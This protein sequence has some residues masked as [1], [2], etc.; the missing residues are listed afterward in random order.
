MN[1]VPPGTGPLSPEFT[2]I[3][4]ALMDRFI[5]EMEHARGLIGEHTQAIRQ[6]FATEGVPATSLDPISEVERWIDE[7]LPDLR[8]RSKMAHDTAKLPDWS[9]GAANGLMSYEEK[10]VLPAAE[11]RRLGAELAA[12]YKKLDSGVLSPLS[13][14]QSYQRI[15]DALASHVNDPE[16]TAAFFA[17]L[18]RQGTL[19]LPATLRHNLAPP[20]EAT[21]APPRSDDGVLRT[22]SQAFGTAVSAGSHVP[23]F[24]QIKDSLANTALSGP[25]Q[26][27]AGLL[28]SAGSFPAK[29]L[30]QVAATQGLGKPRNV[31]AGLLYA[32]GN[33]PG[34]A[35]LALSAVTGQDQSKLIKLLKDFTAHTS[36]MSASA[37]E[38]DAFGRMLAAASGAY[39]EKDGQH[40][41]DAAAFAFTVMTTLGGLNIGR[42]TRIHLSEIAGAY[43]TEIAEG[44]DFSD[45]NHL[46]PSAFGE[47]TSQTP[48]LKPIFRL[49]PK[50]TYRFI[51]TFSDSTANQRPFRE[52]M[53]NLAHR[54][55]NAEVPAMLK[56]EDSTRLSDVFAALGNVAGLQLAAEKKHSKAA[57]DAD[58]AAGKNF[59]TI[60]GNALGVIGIFIPGEELGATLW[61]LLSGAWSAWDTYKPD[62]EKEGEKVDK[63][64]HEETLGRQHGIAQSLIDAGIKPKVSL[65]DYQTMY[66]SGASIVG[67]DDKLRPFAEILKSKKSGSLESLDRWLL[68]NGMGKSSQ[69]SIGELSNRFADRFEGKKERTKERALD[70]E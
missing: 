21:L 42:A 25:D 34:A 38:A 57:D 31:N 61:T 32:L 33:N 69:L 60:S 56:S 62:R 58:D 55:I 65:R 41:K 37:G 46:L 26:V 5:S 14:D 67:D 8:R 47:V 3:D 53:G 1:T 28:L 11:A 22:I 49:S 50:D 24:S 40:S 27:N 16:Y 13:R 54:L 68:E 64:N 48:G 44:A 45:A 2:G 51:E 63:A 19:D 70:F 18:G 4:P 23:G 7:R 20:G 6:V 52:G 36:S 10:D 35:R 29:W 39:D 9:P 66:P 59:S 43:A 17:A 15:V 12:T 30:A